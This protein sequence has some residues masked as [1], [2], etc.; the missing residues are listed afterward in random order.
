MKASNIRSLSLNF[1]L[2]SLYQCSYLGSPNSSTKS[3]NNKLLDYPTYTKPQVYEGMEVPKV[4]LSGDHKK[5]AEYR[6]QEQIK[7]TKE[8]RP[9]LMEE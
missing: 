6:K 4:L 1:K 2:S 3:F 7:K 9:D 8:L 5:I